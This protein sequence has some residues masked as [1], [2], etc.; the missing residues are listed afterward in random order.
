MRKII[1]LIIAGLLFTNLTYAQ[2]VV[3]TSVNINCIN[4]NSNLK[5]GIRG[6]SDVIVLQNFLKEKGYLSVNATGFFGPLTLSAV[7][8]FQKSSN[9]SATGF[10]GPLTRASINKITCT[11]VELPRI[12]NINNTPITTI[13]IPDVVTPT[14]PEVV[15]VP[16]AEDVILTAPNNS[17][18]R[19]R[20][21]SS[22]NITT[23]SVSVKGTVTAGARSGTEVWFE[24]TTNA[25]VY[26]TSETIISPKVVQKTN[27]K[28]EYIFLNL[29]S[30]TNYYY[31][32]CAGN[33]SL[34]QRSCGGT[35]TVKTN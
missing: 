33:T 20:T 17:S 25:N 22:L 31:R 21:D 2:E 16:V 26:K 27:E 14:E 15:I 7:K 1:F 12:E 11:F 9:I 3:V 5:Q 13:P 34:G 10:V 4:L 35:T 28:F 23:D 30:N 6:S 29:N 19:V 18:L 8:A 24:L 32:A